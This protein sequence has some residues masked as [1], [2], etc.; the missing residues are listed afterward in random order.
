MKDKKDKK[1]SRPGLSREAIIT[2]AVKIVDE[3]GFPALSMRRLGA[4]L[5]VDPMAVYY[6]IPNKSALLDGLVDQV[7]SEIDLSRDD[8]LKPAA[9]RLRVAAHVYREVLLAHPN[10]M[11]VIAA[12][13]PSTP[14][15]FRPVELL[16]GIFL[17]AG[18]S[19]TDALAAVNIFARVVRGV[20]LTEVQQVFGE[21]E[22]LKGGGSGARKKDSCDDSTCDAGCASPSVYLPPEEFPFMNEVM[23]KAVFIGFEEEF[24]RGVRA[25]IRGLMETF[26]NEQEESDSD[27]R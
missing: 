26:A 9:E 2:M 21:G 27:A 22:M 14:V 5:G 19:A 25:L 7:M 17:D 4:V 10:A 15:A 1:E 20:V 16:L 24:D 13:A 3:E 6:H 11:V 18:F 12:R 8:P 23:K